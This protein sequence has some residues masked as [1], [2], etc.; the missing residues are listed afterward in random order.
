MEVAQM[1]IVMNE[2]K[3]DLFMERLRY[4]GVVER[5][6]SAT[7]AREEPQLDSWRPV[8]RQRA[9]QCRLREEILPVL[10]GR[11][12][13]TDAAG[14]LRCVYGGPHGELGGG[15]PLT[16]SL[17]ELRMDLRVSRRPGAGM[18]YLQCLEHD[19][20]RVDRRLGRRLGHAARRSAGL[21]MV[22]RQLCQVPLVHPGVEPL[23]TSG[24]L[25]GVEERAGRAVVRQPVPDGGEPPGPR[26]QLDCQLLVL[27]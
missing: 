26:G 22:G 17:Q 23:D 25:A 15:D 5:R 16:E 20:F 3:R 21:Q 9:P 8:K 2:E 12:D 7:V 27:G 10:A 1:D 18:S 19:E 6:Q 11:T 24:E 4:G 14:R 13:D